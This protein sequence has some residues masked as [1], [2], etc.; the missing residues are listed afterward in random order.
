MMTDVLSSED[1]A[2]LCPQS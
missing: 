2:V 1:D